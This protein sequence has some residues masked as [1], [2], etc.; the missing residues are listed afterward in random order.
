MINKIKMLVSLYTV[1]RNARHEVKFSG[2]VTG[3]QKAAGDMAAYLLS[4]GCS[5]SKA[6]EV[7]AKLIMESIDPVLSS[8]EMQFNH[9]PDQYDWSGIVLK[10]IIE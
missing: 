10:K 4:Q 6:V 2:G 8:F 3:S 1:I 9:A 5:E 7:A